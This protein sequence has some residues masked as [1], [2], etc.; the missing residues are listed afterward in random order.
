MNVAIFARPD[1]LSGLQ[2]GFSG[3]HDRLTLKDQPRV[4]QFVFAG[5]AIYNTPKLEWLNEAALLRHDPRGG[6][7]AR[8]T[9]GF[10]T[11]VARR[12][13]AF[14]PYLR[15]EYLHAPGHDPVLSPLEVSGV[16]HGPSFGLRWD[17]T[18]YAALKMQ[19]D[20]TV[21]RHRDSLN[22]FTLQ[23]AFPF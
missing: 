17:F 21:N 7:D 3:Y 16:R 9:S 12:F 14:T 10:Y 22:E 6:D 23:P 8:Y 1:W 2:A 15:Y 5:H 11:Q 19:F 4:D 18:D 20:H 13:G